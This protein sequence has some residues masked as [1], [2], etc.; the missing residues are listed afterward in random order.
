MILVDSNILLDVIK[1]DPVWARWSISRLQDALLEGPLAINPVIYSE[2]AVGYPTIEDLEEFIAGTSLKMMEIPRP[3]L[4]LAGKAFSA[5]RRAGGS[6]TGVLPDFFIGAH[7]AALGIP[8]LTRDVQRYKTYF[9][10]VE[11]ISPTDAN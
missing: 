9:P 11:L 6:R 1:A 5:Y 4:F 7:A 3:G 2:L 10:G 8:V